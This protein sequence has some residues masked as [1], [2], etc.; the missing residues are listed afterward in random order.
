MPWFGSRKPV[1]KAP[2]RSALVTLRE[3]LKKLETAAEPTQQIA[4]LKS[5][6]AERIR[7]MERE[8]A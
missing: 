3:T 2:A 5:I 7:E 6:L 1:S 8:S 4:E